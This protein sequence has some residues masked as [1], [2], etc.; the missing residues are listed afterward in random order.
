M[1]DSDPVDVRIL[2]SE[3]FNIESWI[4]CAAG[5]FLQELVP[6]I[7]AAVSVDMFGHPLP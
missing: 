2:L 6:S 5:S 7:A 1:E 3:V 4:E